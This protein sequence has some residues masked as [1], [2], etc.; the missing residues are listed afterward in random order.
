MRTRRDIRTQAKYLRRLNG[1]LGKFKFF[2]MLLHR[3]VEVQNIDYD[4]HG[5]LIGFSESLPRVI[6]T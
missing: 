6:M 1:L 5:F 2:S 4:G 3:L